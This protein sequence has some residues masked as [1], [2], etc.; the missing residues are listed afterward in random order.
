MDG[1]N[2]VASRALD[3]AVQA[4][5]SG[6]KASAPTAPV[7]APEIKAPIS[8]KAV[9]DA[10]LRQQASAGTALPHPEQVNARIEQTPTGALQNQALDIPKPLRL[11]G[12]TS[13]PSPLNHLSN[14]QLVQTLMQSEGANGP[15]Y[16]SILRKADEIRNS[17]ILP[18]LQELASRNIEVPASELN[19][20]VSDDAVLVMRD[21]A[22]FSPERIAAL[23]E[24][25]YQHPEV[26][27]DLDPAIAKAHYGS[28]KHK[29]YGALVESLTGGILSAEEAMAMNPA[30]G[31][32]GAG[33]S[34]IPLIGRID[35]VS[36]HA[37]RHDATGFL[38]TRFGVGPGYGSPTTPVGL[39]SDN[40]LAGQI[41]GLAREAFGTSSILPAFQHVASAGRFNETRQA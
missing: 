31:L 28:D 30:G 13:P 38:R 39:S 8:N 11:L 29:E 37:M 19:R 10:K 36:R 33:A 14:D 34:E 18:D 5:V 25:A 1:M 27:E 6:V 22:R 21:F 26:S 12:L 17:G 7:S 32:P 9:F 20:S 35:A 24:Q 2:K 40:P 16:G 15:R 3:Q 23:K 4:R 41:L